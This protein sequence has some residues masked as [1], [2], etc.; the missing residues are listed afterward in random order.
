METFVLE[1]I[2]MYICIYTNKYI[3]C[4]YSVSDNYAIQQFVVCVLLCFIP[5]ILGD[6]YG[7][8]GSWRTS[9]GST[10]PRFR[11]VLGLFIKGR[12]SLRRQMV[13]VLH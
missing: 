9:Q 10:H 13:I 2:N 12:T 6:R 11:S 4:L 5:L 3:L 7:P 1:D 8:G